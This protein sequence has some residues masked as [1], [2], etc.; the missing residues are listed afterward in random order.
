MADQWVRL[1][2]AIIIIALISIG[3]YQLSGR[4]NAIQPVSPVL[5]Y[6]R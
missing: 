6:Q 5:A 2:T 4:A 1:G 3:L